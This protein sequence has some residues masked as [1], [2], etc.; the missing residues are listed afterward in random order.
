LVQLGPVAI[1]LARRFHEL[2]VGHP[3]L[4]GTAKQLMSNWCGLGASMHSASAGDS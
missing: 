3:R 4:A 1:G 2:S